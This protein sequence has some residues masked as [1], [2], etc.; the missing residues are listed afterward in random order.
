M[1]KIRTTYQTRAN[2]PAAGHDRPDLILVM[3]RR[4][5][6]AALEEPRHA[7]RMRHESRT[8][9]DQA[10][11]FVGIRADDAQW[12]NLSQRIGRGALGRVDRAFGGFYRRVRQGQKAGY[13]RFQSTGLGGVSPSMLKRSEDGRRAYV[14]IKRLPTLRLDATPHMPEGTPRTMVLTRHPRRMGGEHGV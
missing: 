2:V 3:C 10:K 7:Y 12:C 5:Y 4:L 11:E 6:N 1:C 8:Y 9:Y 14:T 13:P